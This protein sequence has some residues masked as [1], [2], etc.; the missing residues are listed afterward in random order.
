MISESYL[1]D[2]LK[3]FK[4]IRLKDILNDYHKT[5][6]SINKKFEKKGR[7]DYLVKRFGSIEHIRSRLEEGKSFKNWTR[8]EMKEILD[9]FGVPFDE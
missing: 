5:L 3:M 4:D 2:F 9:S 7:F 6:S 8:E 1:F